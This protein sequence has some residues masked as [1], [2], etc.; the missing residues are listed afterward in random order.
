[1][2]V[3]V[4]EVY[5]ALVSAG[6]TEEKARAAAG[7]VRAGA[8]VADKA[9][10]ARIDT[11]LDGLDQRLGTIEARLS[12]TSTISELAR[13]RRE[14]QEQIAAPNWKSIVI[15]TVAIAV[16]LLWFL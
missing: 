5:D 8:E 15:Q 1:M 12:V 9:D 16:I 4:T 13:T 2:G 10:A 7:A 3:I 11:R 14:L 6:A